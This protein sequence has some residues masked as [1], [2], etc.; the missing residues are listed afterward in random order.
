MG[1]VGSFVTNRWPL[2]IGTL[3][4]VTAL[5]LLFAGQQDFEVSLRVPLRTR[6]LPAEFE[7]VEPQKPEL[8]IT[9]RGL[10]KDAST[11][12]DRNVHA[13][14]DLSFA[15]LGRRTFRV[16]REHILLP[17]ETISI[18]NVQPPDFQFHFEKR[19]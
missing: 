2:K 1:K 8:V 3:L 14:I 19:E 6:N 18:V 9:V 13:E 10:R 16:S 4:F 11:L 15:A 12:N 5:W 17:T 7:I